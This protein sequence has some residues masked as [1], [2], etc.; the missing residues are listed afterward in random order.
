E[1]KYTLH[2]GGAQLFLL[3]KGIAYQFTKT[4]YPEGYE[5]MMT[6]TDGIENFEKMQELQKKVRIEMSRMD[7]TLLGANTSCK[8]STERKSADYTNFYTYDVLGVHSFKKVIY[9]DIYPNIDWVIYTNDGQV[10]Y[11]FVV[12]PG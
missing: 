3:E 4:H 12:K 10:K 9:H 7:M 2:Q 6:S 8:I 11:D 5:K 1:I